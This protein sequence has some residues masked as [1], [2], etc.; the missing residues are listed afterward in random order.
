MAGSGNSH[1]DLDNTFLY[2]IEPS[3][4]TPRKVYNPSPLERTSVVYA[5]DNRT[6]VPQVHNSR[7]RAKRKCP[8]SCSHIP[9]VEALA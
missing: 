7:S 1:R 9:H 5:H 8:V 6:P 4:S 3:R 2:H